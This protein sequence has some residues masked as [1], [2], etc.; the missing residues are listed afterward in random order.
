MTPQLDTHYKYDTYERFYYLT[1]TGAELLTGLDD[2]DGLWQNAERRLKS[3]GRLLKSLMTL[4]TDDDNRERRSK[5]DYV[6]YAQ[7]IDTNK[8]KSVLIMLSHMAE[9]A[10]DVDGD[11]IAYEERNPMD[12]FKLLPLPL[13]IEGRNSGLLDLAPTTFIVPE[14]EYQVGY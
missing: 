9:W 11:R 14:D 7:Y 3:Q 10:Y 13:R 4:A 6:E 8:R 2:L 5:Q 1:P 12:V